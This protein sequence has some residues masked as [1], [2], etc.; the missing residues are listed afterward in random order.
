MRRRQL[1]GGIAC[2]LGCVLLL[3]SGCG[4]THTIP[5]GVLEVHNERFSRATIHG[6]EIEEIGG[7]NFLAYD[8]WA[9]PGDTIAL[10]VFPSLYDV[11]LF[12]SDGGLET[13]VGVEVMECCTTI[14]DARR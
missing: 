4:R 1:R 12:W 2:V 10:D 11:T 7:P 13:F 3:A 5:E 8:V 14:L 6:L 9:R